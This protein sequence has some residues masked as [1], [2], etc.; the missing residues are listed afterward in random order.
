MTVLL[1]FFRFISLW[2]TVGLFRK[3]TFVP[4]L[5]KLVHQDSW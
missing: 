2:V 1:S 4:I 5:L 3:Q